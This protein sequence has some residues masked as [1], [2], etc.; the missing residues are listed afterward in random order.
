MRTFHA[1]LAAL[2]LAVAA[3]LRA[4]RLSDP[5]PVAVPAGLGAADLDKSIA[6]ALAARGWVAGPAEPGRV[7]AAF[8]H[9]GSV[10]RVAVTWDSQAVRITYQDS[11][12]LDYEDSGGQREID[13]EYNAW[14][15]ALAGEIARFDAGPKPRIARPNPP[16]SEKFSAFSNFELR[17]LTMDPAYTGSINEHVRDKLDAQLHRALW[18][19]IGAWTRTVPAGAQRTLLIEPRIEKLR[20]VG[21]A[22]RAMVG[23]VAGNSFI[24][25]RVVCTDAATGAVVA[26]PGFYREGTTDASLI[27]AIHDNGDSRMLST[28]SELVRLYL[29]GNYKALAGGASGDPLPES[30]AAAS[31]SR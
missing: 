21:G 5:A 2:L 12:D 25:V 30:A 6:R 13:G 7:V 27:A 24:A 10:A 15:Q 3:P 16:P 19:L 22:V 28:I 31:S 29:V 14:V 18:P 17:P 20:Y 9:L 26:S 4:D 11:T 23:E 1:G 8:D